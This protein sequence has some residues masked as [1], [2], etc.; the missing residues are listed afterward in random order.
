MDDFMRANVD[1][2]RNVLDA[3]DA[4][5]A[6]RVVHVS[7]VAAF[8]WEV[9]EE[10]AEDA[11]PRTGTGNPYFETKALSE[12]V[13]RERGA[14]VVRPG[15]VYGPGS[16]QWSVRPL[17]LLRARMLALPA[18]GRGLVTPVYIDDL[19]D[20]LVRALLHPEAAGRAFTAWEGRP[21]ASR[22]F[23]GHYARMLG[24]G[25][26]PVA[27]LPALIAYARLA[28]AT[29]RLTGRPP[30]VTRAALRYLC[31]R[32]AYSTTQARGVLGWEPR[33]DLDE[34]MRRTEAWFRDI[35]LLGERGTRLV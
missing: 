9:D 15:D 6:E 13:A 32:A 30:G 35:G 24:R 23:F 16:Q 5:G 2:T 31:R 3:A 14:T 33:V 4:H 21:V 29:A 18:R 1:G 25:R 34:G 11:E 7:S 26:V 10:I 28:E 19:V 8:G 22:D 12:R 20:C 27:P 17:R